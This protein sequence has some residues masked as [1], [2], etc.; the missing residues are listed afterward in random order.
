MH[1][2]DI[3]KPLFIDLFAGCGGF[4]LGMEKAGFHGLGAVEIDAPTRRTLEDN[5]G[6]SPLRSIRES[7]GDIRSINP[8]QLRRELRSVGIADL[9]VLV[10]CPPCQGFSRVGRGKL[11]SLKGGSGSFHADPRNNLYRRA[12]EFLS[13]L[14]PKVFV[15]E[16]VPG[17][18]FMR[19][20]NVA[21][22]VCRDAREAGYVVRCALLNAAWYGVPQLRERVIIIGWRKDLGVTPEFPKIRNFGAALEGH[23]SV[24]DSPA[25]FWSN[26]ELFVPY[27]RLRKGASLKPLRTVG[28]AFADLPSFTLH[29]KALRSGS[30]YKAIRTAFPPTPYAT[31]EAPNEYC[32]LM[33]SWLR[34]SIEPQVTDHFCRWTPR[35]FETFARMKAGDRYDD[36]VRIAEARYREAATLYREGE[37]GR[38][39]RADFV[40]PYRLDAFNEK[41]RKLDRHK[42]SWT[43]TAHLSKDTYSHI[44]FD[45]RQARAIT[46]REAARL[47]SFPDGFRIH[48]NSGDAFRQI[49]N[50]VP[51]LLAEAIG[52]VIGRQLAAVH[53]EKRRAK[54]NEQRR[55]E[56][57][58]PE[59][60][61][62]PEIRL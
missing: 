45:S 25:E 46:V 30:R 38:P 14:K 13:V 12:T 3:N 35:D 21:E 24:S 18:I 17:M 16:N 2:R 50:A 9:D 58:A 59:W 29:L 5:F 26:G 33:R 11:N 55:D 60:N 6:V 41:W 40:P 44:H 4:S 43:L 51:P 36:A 52:V 10:A 39:K 32:A 23:T 61:R 8:R 49:G 42:P 47:Q 7:D 48:G 22:R 15:F 57:G 19:G 31:A 54:Q 56:G 27:S 28:E 34:A 37:A 53:D 20:Q 1:P 62:S